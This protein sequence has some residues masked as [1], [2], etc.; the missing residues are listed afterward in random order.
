MHW[1]KLLLEG[2]FFLGLTTTA[3]GVFWTNKEGSK[4]TAPNTASPPKMRPDFRAKQLSEA[5]SA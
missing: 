3:W 4:L 2:W 1:I 5:R